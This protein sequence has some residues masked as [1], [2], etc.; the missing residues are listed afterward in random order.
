MRDQIDSLEI[1][2]QTHYYNSRSS[3]M[4]LVTSTRDTSLMMLLGKFPVRVVLFVAC[5][6]TC[7]KSSVAGRW[8][9]Y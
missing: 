8:G 4:H 3:L 9:N 2:L 7:T 5:T 1:N 6:Y